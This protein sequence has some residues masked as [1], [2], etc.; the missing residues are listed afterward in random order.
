MCL[1]LTL[2]INIRNITNNKDFIYVGLL[3]Y[4]LIPSIIEMHFRR[5]I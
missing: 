1:P 3:E 2:S 5:P 4:I